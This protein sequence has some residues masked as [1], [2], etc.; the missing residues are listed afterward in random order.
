MGGHIEPLV[1]LALLGWLYRDAPKLLPRTAKFAR[2][3]IVT[4]II[5]FLPYSIYSTLYGFASWSP[6]Q[7]MWLL[8]IEL[9]AGVGTFL[10][11]C[12]GAIALILDAKRMP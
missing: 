11:L 8:A 1:M 9:L 12:W 6:D 3:G 7:S 10:A 5:L 2:C 4:A